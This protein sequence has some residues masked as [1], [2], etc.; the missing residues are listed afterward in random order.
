M[1]I[2]NSKCGITRC[3]RKD[4]NSEYNATKGDMRN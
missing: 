2:I 3:T 1:E 4:F